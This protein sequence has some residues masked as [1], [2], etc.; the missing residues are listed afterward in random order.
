MFQILTYIAIA[1]RTPKK[2]KSKKISFI[3]GL[4]KS[5]QLEKKQQQQGTEGTRNTPITVDTDEKRLKME[6][7]SVSLSDEHAGQKRKRQNSTSEGGKR[8]KVID[9]VC[10]LI[11][12]L[13]FIWSNSAFPIADDVPS[14]AA[15]RY[16]GNQGAGSTR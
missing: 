1:H 10:S 3:A 15:G 13:L 4:Q 7:A 2:P 12:T 11:Y 6:E 9:E 5:M 8:K 16:Q 14:R